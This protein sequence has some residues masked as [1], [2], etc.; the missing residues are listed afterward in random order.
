MI[1][2]LVKARIPRAA[3]QA[4]LALAPS[5][6]WAA[7]RPADE[8]SLDVRILPLGNGRYGPEPR[9][10]HLFACLPEVFYTIKHTGAHGPGPW[11]HEQSWDLT[12]KPVVQGAATWPDA[13]LSI[14]VEGESRIIKGNG[15]P[16]GAPT[17][18]FPIDKNDPAFAWDPN[19]NPIGPQS[20]SL[21]LPRNPV[22]LE[23]PSCIELPVGV[24]L[25]GV[26]FFSALD[27]HGRDE[28]AYEMQDS[29]GGM[30]SPSKMY[31]R[32]M[33]TDCIPHIRE[34]AALVGYALDG[35]GVFS[36]YDENGKELSTNDL[37]E[38]HGRTSLITWDGETRVMYHYV[39]THDFPYSISCFRGAP[40]SIR[41]PPPPPPPIF[42]F[43]H[44]LFSGRSGPPIDEVERQR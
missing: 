13:R 17:G 16:L 32:Y 39:L 31:H 4:L 27:S 25:D 24:G 3:L 44:G 42:E 29:C 21:S 15:L 19:P 23:R 40:T 22:S 18:V 35:Y 26:V 12:Q 11:I 5:L 37:D 34:P 28:P 10:G 20:I 33:P 1:S 41:L 38:C 30:S 8:K 6:L 36:P 2:T 7:D 43:L 9:K 14:H